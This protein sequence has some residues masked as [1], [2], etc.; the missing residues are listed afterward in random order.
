MDLG[1]VYRSV[2]FEILV[3]KLD[4][5]VR[6]LPVACVLWWVL[7]GGFPVLL[8]VRAGSSKIK[9]GNGSDRTN[10]NERNER[11]IILPGGAITAL[12]TRSNRKPLRI[13]DD[14]MKK[15]MKSTEALRNRSPTEVVRG[16]SLSLSTTTSPPTT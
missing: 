2:A 7:K 16:C 14:P 9:S 4:G 15:E 8:D 13:L 1:P 11:Q 10:T 3:G 5:T 6:S 12:T